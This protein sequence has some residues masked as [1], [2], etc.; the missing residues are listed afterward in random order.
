[1]PSMRVQEMKVAIV[2]SEYQKLYLLNFSV[3]VTLYTY[4]LYYMLNTS[5]VSNSL[6][7]ND[8]AK[9]FLFIRLYSSSVATTIFLLFETI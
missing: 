4:N 8:E 3:Y 2:L 6:C 5:S 7:C 1:M 9:T